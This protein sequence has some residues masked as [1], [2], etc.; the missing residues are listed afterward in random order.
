[1]LR[2]DSSPNRRFRYTE[3]RID[4]GDPMYVLGNFE[5]ITRGD[6]DDEDFDPNGGVLALPQDGV[7]ADNLAPRGGGVWWR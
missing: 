6:D 2:I 3:E 4:D 1:M 7:T 5:R